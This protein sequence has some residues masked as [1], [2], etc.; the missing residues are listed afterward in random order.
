MNRLFSFDLISVWGQ[1]FEDLYEL[2]IMLRLIA[3]NCN[4]NEDVFKNVLSY[5]IQGRIKF[6]RYRAWNK[7]VRD[8]FV[9]LL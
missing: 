9:C 3:P 1:Y 4:K 5:L 8:V 2:E 6:I 7:E